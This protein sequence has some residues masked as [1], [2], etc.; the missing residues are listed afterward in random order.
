MVTFTEDQ[1][2]LSELC[3]LGPWDPPGGGAC[4]SKDRMMFIRQKLFYSV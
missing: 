3:G 1:Q 4:V 2:S